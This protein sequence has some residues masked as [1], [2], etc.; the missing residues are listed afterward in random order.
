MIGWLIDWLIDWLVDYFHRTCYSSGFLCIKGVFLTSDPLCPLCR[1]EIPKKCIDHPTVLGESPKTQG[2]RKRKKSASSS[3][4]QPV[5]QTPPQISPQSSV[6]SPPRLVWFYE[7]RKGGWWQY[8]E[9]TLAAIDEAQAKGE[10]S[11]EVML[12]G[13]IYVL[14]FTMKIQM[15]KDNPSVSRQMKK[16]FVDSSVKGVAGLLVARDWIERR[17]FYVCIVRCQ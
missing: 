3:F 13:S 7:G 4:S 5:S 15:R 17:R 9:R 14:D 8:D 11:L 1:A 16:D 6:T 2:S 10:T 12:S